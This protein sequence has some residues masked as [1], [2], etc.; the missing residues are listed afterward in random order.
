ML[1]TLLLSTT[2][3]RPL[4]PIR[5][6]CS[7]AERHDLRTF[8]VSSHRLHHS[9]L[10][11]LLYESHFCNF[12]LSPFYHFSSIHI[13]G[14]RR[15]PMRKLRDR[16]LLCDQQVKLLLFTFN[17]KLEHSTS[18]EILSRRNCQTPPHNTE[19]CFINW[20]D[21]GRDGFLLRAAPRRSEKLRNI[22]RAD[23]E[24]DKQSGAVFSLSYLNG[25]VS[26]GFSM[27]CAL[28]WCCLFEYCF[29]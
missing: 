13:T 28:W 2:P 5:A 22:Y 9:L 6:R 27:W 16:Q 25:N 4:D 17:L 15:G 19:I 1:F 24:R 18:W 10:M 20:N 26:D 11:A 21:D 23:E 29:A 3:C 12:L 8:C 14:E 7:N